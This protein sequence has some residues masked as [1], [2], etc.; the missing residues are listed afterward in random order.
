MVL[1]DYEMPL[2]LPNLKNIDKALIYELGQKFKYADGL[3]FCAP[4]YNGGSPPI[5]TNVITWLSVITDNFRE[6]FSNKKALIGTHS[7]GAGAEVFINIPNTIRTS[8]GYCFSKDH[9]GK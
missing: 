9:Y 1:E 5:L 4:E 2:Y 3:I 6:L 7:G 8:W